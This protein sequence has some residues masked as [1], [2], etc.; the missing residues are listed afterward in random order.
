MHTYNAHFFGKVFYSL[1]KI[2]ST[3]N[4]LQNLQKTEKLA[5]GT[6]VI[7]KHQTA[8]KGQ[9]GNHW[10]D[11]PGSNIAM[12]L[13]IETDFLE[14]VAQ[15]YL[16]M[17]ISLALAEGLSRL[18][19]ASICLK[20]P[21]D[22]YFDDQKLGGILIENSSL[23]KYLQDSIVGI[24]INV[25]QVFF[26]ENLPNPTSLKLISGLE[27][28][29]D[30]VARSLLDYLEERYLQLKNGNF[31][32]IKS[33]YLK[34]LYR[35]QEKAPYLIN[36]QKIEGKIVDVHQDGRLV[37]LIEGKKR[38]FDLKEIQFV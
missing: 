34:K 32:S 27:Y 7:A 1:N 29:V 19:N 17:A 6:L 37:V 21:N 30:D 12:S 3:N 31:Q 23:G 9:R 14:I 4:F 18:L 5:N 8:G 22:L 36:E 33:D 26:P 10:H 25:N 15:F 28:R 20:W 11:E 13:Y 38:L 16:S 24:G 2:D 35:Y